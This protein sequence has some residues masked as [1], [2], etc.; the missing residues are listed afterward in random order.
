MLKKRVVYL[1][2]TSL[3]MT[4]STFAIESENQKKNDRKIKLNYELKLGITPFKKYGSETYSE[5][6]NNGVDFGAEVYKSGLKY[7]FGFGGEVKRKLDDE[8]ITGKTGKLYTYYFLGKRK[9]GNFYSLVTRL[10][11]TNQAEFESDFYG[12]LGI[13]K[14]IGRINIQLLGET[15][16]L[17]NSLNDKRYTSVG[18]KVGYVFGN[19]YDSKIEVDEP[20]E[21]LEQVTV[22]EEPFVLQEDILISRYSAYEVKVPIE[23]KIN[24]QELVKKINK[25]NKPG[26]LRLKAYSDNTG[27][28][29]VNVR[30]AKER[31]NSIEEELKVNGLND[32][33]KVEK[34]TPEITIGNYK[35]DNKT[36][37]NRE[38]NRRVE[39][40]FIEE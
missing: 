25:Y 13:E 40:T 10:G 39:V 16:K 24:L 27:S 38:K 18:L 23:Q 34:I 33:I 12:A 30:L 4:T 35:V 36:L 2:M 20:K 22:K 3:F 6:F 29:E 11:G 15:T 28:K 8:Y 14:S 17:K 5:R 1:F 19:L 31:M 21:V 26:T 9:V 37:K 32:E 7:Q